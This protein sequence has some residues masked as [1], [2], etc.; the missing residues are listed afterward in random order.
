MIFVCGEWWFSLEC[1]SS[2]EIFARRVA[3]S[4]VFVHR[5]KNSFIR[6]LEGQGRRREAYE[7]DDDENGETR[8]NSSIPPHKGEIVGIELSLWIYPLK[9]EWMKWYA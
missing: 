6:E 7:D 1:K 8:K 5:A 2:Q 4:F 3:C 9:E